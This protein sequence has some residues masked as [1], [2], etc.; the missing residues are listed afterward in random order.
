MAC[1]GVGGLKDVPHPLT[2]GQNGAETDLGFVIRAD[3]ELALTRILPGVVVA[4]PLLKVK[5][6]RADKASSR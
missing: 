4:A 1:V 3:L 2:I 6:S 5:V